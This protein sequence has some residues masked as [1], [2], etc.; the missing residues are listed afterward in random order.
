MNRKSKANEEF[1]TVDNLTF[2]KQNFDTIREWLLTRVDKW[3]SK[4]KFGSDF[5]FSENFLA[6]WAVA[7]FSYFLDLI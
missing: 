4:M 3:L 6:N 5:R 2:F 7:D 1:K